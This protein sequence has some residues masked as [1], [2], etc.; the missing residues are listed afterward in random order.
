MNVIRLSGF[1]GGR[2]DEGA[3]LADPEEEPAEA[4]GGVGRCVQRQEDRQRYC[5]QCGLHSRSGTGDRQPQRGG[6]S[7]RGK[8]EIFL[9]H[10][11]V[12]ECQQEVSERLQLILS[13]HIVLYLSIIY[14]NLLSSV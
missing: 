9:G 4:A 14:F 11:G 13:P 2:Q 3:D 1:A 8:P 6:E 7:Q 12:L 5:L 10:L